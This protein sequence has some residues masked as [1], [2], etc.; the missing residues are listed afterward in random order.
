MEFL[1]AIKDGVSSLSSKMKG[2]LGDL[3]GALDAVQGASAALGP[4]GAVA[5]Q[6][7]SA[8]GTAAKVTIGVVLG[9]TA[10]IAAL[11][12]EGAKLAIE[13]GEMRAKTLSALS[14]LAGG[15]A[16]GAGMLAMIRKLR[17][18]VPDSEQD[19]TR[20]AKSLLGAGVAAKDMD[21]Y[22]RAVAGANAVVEGGGEK[23][24]SML[25]GLTEQAEGVGKLKFAIKSL[26]GVGI[27]EKEFINALGMTPQAFALAK[28][29]GKIGGTQIAEAIVKAVQ[30][31]TAGALAEQANSLSA[32]WGRFKEGLMQLFEGVASTPGYKAFVSG[33]KDLLGIF[34]ATTASGK[35]MKAGITGAF[36]AIFG[37]ASKVLPY[38]KIGIEK[39]I[40]A[41]LKAYIA[42]KPVVKE[43]IASGAATRVWNGLVSVVH[44]FGV[45]IKIVGYAIL[46]TIRLMAGLSAAG[47][48]FNEW[49]TAGPKAA[50]ALIDGLVSGISSGVARVVA[51]VKSLGTSVL[52]ALTGILGIHSPSR[53]FAKLGMMAGA[54]F[55]EG[56]SAS[57]KGVSASASKL[58]TG[59]AAGAKPQAP[60]GKV[61]GKSLTVNVES[62]AIQIN[63]AK[64][65]ASSLTEVAVAAL[66]ERIAITQG[67][68]A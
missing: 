23:L 19:L 50:S 8:I 38:V 47:K 7:I 20:W 27:S 53:E 17:Q 61:G 41:A 46:G 57:A 21:R 43:F 10:A 40:I 58:G 52:G 31:K 49:V 15:P 64:G 28:K 9:L 5:G 2:A 34:G 56:I 6:A 63:G 55:S 14:A 44:A 37:W 22:L 36:G 45:A 54:G 16:A 33:L 51:A 60:Q 67:L 29:T 68:G 3:N 62:G 13:A 59:A 39:I 24:V 32:I 30:G 4:A 25:A 48:A 1:I 65:D 42:L 66:F 11:V 12:V 18:D 26:A 35:A